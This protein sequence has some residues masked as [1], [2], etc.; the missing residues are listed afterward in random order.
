[1]GYEPKP[2][3]W[4][5]RV[6]QIPSSMDYSYNL[7]MGLVDSKMSEEQWMNWVQ[8]IRSVD[9]KIVPESSCR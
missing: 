3:G 6:Y 5:E 2:N 1:M 4:D 8:S 9:V 7:I